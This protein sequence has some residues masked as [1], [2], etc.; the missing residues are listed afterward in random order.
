MKYDFDMIVIGGGAAGLTSSGVS[1]GFGA[2]TMMIEKDRLGGDCTW[3]GCVPSKILLNEAKKQWISRGKA[4]FAKISEKLHHI[5]EEVYRD[6]DHP[7]IFINMGI[8]VV[9][10]DAR[11]V[12]PHEIEVKS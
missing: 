8:E 10:G 4:D 3:H 6:A 9:S 2:K 12:S 5:R 1:A 11:F 7:D